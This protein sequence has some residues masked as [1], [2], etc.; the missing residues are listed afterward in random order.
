MSG[1][2]WITEGWLD[3]IE[4]R[5]GLGGGLERGSGRPLS[6]VLELVAGGGMRDDTRAEPS[7]GAGASAAS[8]CQDRA[9]GRLVFERCSPVVAAPQCLRQLARR[10][11]GRCGQPHQRR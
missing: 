11:A 8:G 2:Q 10:W 6:F 7:A 5:R 4:K 1:G 9:I 3:A